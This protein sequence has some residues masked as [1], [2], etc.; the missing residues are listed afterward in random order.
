MWFGRD[1]KAQLQ[2]HRLGQTSALP[3]QDRLGDV[4]VPQRG[5]FMTGSVLFEPSVPGPAIVRADQGG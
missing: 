4:W 5:L 1:S 3:V 2:G